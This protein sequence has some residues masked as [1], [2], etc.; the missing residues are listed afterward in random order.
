MFGL[1]SIPKLVVLAAVILIVWY[2]FKLLS[3]A[4]SGSSA[5][6]SVDKTGNDGSIETTTCRVCGAY[7]PETGTTSCGRDDCPY[8]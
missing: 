2:G 5:R 1:P 7:V 8:A 6:G 4:G 3:R